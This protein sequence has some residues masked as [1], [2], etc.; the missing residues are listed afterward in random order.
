MLPPDGHRENGIDEALMVGRNS[1]QSQAK[2]TKQ[3]K[4]RSGGSMDLYRSYQI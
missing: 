4:V 1:L 2:K 3:G